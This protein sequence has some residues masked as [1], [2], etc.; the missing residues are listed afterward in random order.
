MAMMN[1]G[2]MCVRVRN[3][4]VS[5]RMRV[6]LVATVGK[7]VSVLMMLVVMMPVRVFEKWV[8]VFVYVPLTHV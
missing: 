1:V 6:R 2:E 4:N 3:R 8:D 5:M 7:I